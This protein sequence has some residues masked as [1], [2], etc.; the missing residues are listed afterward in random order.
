MMDDA[1]NNLPQPSEEEVENFINAAVDD[2]TTG[3]I[4]Y[5]DKYG[6]AF[7][8]IKYLNGCTALMWAGLMGRE[9]A[10]SLLLEK[11]ADICVVDD[12]GRTALVCAEIG[13]DA[14]TVA[15][16][17]RKEQQMQNKLVEINLQQLKQ[18]RPNKSILH[19][20]L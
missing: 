10:A 14:G 6:S 2:N 18:Q 4:T 11:G 1:S 20:K 15:L 13:G 16:L 9:S 8:D 7:V 19:K 3:L 5:L 12:G 17:K